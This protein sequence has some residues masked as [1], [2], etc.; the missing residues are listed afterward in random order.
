MLT[1]S[2]DKTFGDDSLEVGLGEPCQR[3]EVA[4]EE[5]EPVVVVLEVQAAAHARWQLVDEAELAVVVAGANPV[6][7]RAGD[8]AP[9]GSPARLVIS[10]RGLEAATVQLDLDV[11][12][13][14]PRTATR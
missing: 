11:G 10:M 8:L 6:E 4:V 9:N 5:A 7:H 1:L 2:G 14:R 3:R 13:R 12:L